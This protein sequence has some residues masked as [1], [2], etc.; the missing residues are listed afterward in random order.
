MLRARI[1][2]TSTTA[3]HSLS[4]NLSNYARTFKLKY[5]TAVSITLQIPKRVTTN[6]QED[7]FEPFQFILQTKDKTMSISVSPFNTLP[8]PP[9]ACRQAVPQTPK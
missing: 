3:K 5:L 1:E 6:P 2:T 4:N 7:S 9:R 8:G